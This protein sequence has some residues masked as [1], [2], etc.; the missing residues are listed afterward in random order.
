MN[1]KIIFPQTKNQIYLNTAACGL[2]SS[3]VLEQKQRDTQLFFE[4]GSVFLKNEDDIVLQTKLKIAEIFNA[5]VDRIGIT[6]NFSLA[7]NS[8]LDAIDKS[9]TFL[10]LDEDYPSVVL[11]IKQRKFP[12]KSI[13]I[14]SQLEN[15]IYQNVKMHK[16][17]VLALSKVQYLS[18]IQLETSFF[19]D[20]KEEFPNLI[21]LVD[22]TQYLGVEEFDFKHSGID[23]LISSGYKWLNAGLGNAIVMIS[24]ALYEK[25][26]PKQIGSNSVKDKI[27]KTFKPMGFLEPGH[28]D[29]LP[30]KS[31]QT[32][33]ALHYDEIGIKW[34]SQYHKNISQKAFDAFKGLMLLDENVI[35]R[36]QHSSIFNLNISQDRF[37]DFEDA[38]VILS[39][40]GEGLRISFH[41]Y[42][43]IDDLNQFLDFLKTS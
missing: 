13:P 2:M 23:L 27:Q 4:Q 39:K 22:A 38:N 42:N 16:P 41:Y 37:Q 43:T 34:I 20:L 31:L 12:F 36:Q 24:E 25:L 33:L 5:D 7:F 15:D 17:D 40:R 11:P 29:M 32:A 10:I 35:K 21:I 19:Q 9:T 3:K 1:S 30:I 26:K 14:T 18:G 28:Y 8:V 6:P